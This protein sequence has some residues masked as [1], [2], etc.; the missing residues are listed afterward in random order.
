MRDWS[1]ARRGFWV[2]T[3][4][5]VASW[6]AV[7][8]VAMFWQISRLDERQEQNRLVESRSLGE[9]ADLDAEVDRPG[10]EVDYQRVAG[11]ITWLDGQVV[12]IGPRSSGGAPGEWVVGAATLS[13]GRT[14][15]VL[16]GFVEQTGAADEPAVAAPPTGTVRVKGWLRESQQQEFLGRTDD[17]SGLAPRMDVAAIAERLGPGAGPTVG[18]WM[19][20]EDSDP[21]PTLAVVDPPVLN[22]GPH[23]SYAMQWA[24]F[25][26]LTMV[27]Y[28]VMLWRRSGEHPDKV[29][30]RS[31]EHDQPAETNEQ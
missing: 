25:A 8:V 5:F 13:D 30:K 26:L 27:V 28:A 6:I 7:C 10:S 29:T 20:L 14:L 23:L 15:L 12:R 19:Q 17:G 11:D 4:V 3:H 18:V 21:P 22:D 2:F 24:A 9:P 1:F 31:A 16:R